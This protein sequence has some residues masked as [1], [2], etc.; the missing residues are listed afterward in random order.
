MIFKQD[1]F[2]ARLGTH[3]IHRL[4]AHYAETIYSV[5]VEG[6]LRVLCYIEDDVVKTL[7]VELMTCIGRLLA[8]Y[9]L[10]RYFSHDTQN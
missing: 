3:K 2:D 7:V 5:V 4:G 6:D 8:A 9:R 10:W 1:P